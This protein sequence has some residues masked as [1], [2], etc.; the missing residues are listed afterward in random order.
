[1]TATCFPLAQPAEQ[2]PAALDDADTPEGDRPPEEL[3]RRHSGELQPGHPEAEDVDEQDRGNA[4]KEV[5]VH[6]RE[7]ADRE[8]DRA[9]E[10]PQ[11]RDEE[12]ER[13]DDHL[14]DAERA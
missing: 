8:E 2:L 12:G 11:H 7:H 3:R 13:E 14:G 1:M 6:D 10:A 9:L 5:R 4:A